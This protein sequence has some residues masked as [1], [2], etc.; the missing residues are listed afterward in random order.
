MRRAES[1]QERCLRED[2]IRVVGVETQTQCG[3]GAKRLA[4]AY[5]DRAAFARDRGRSAGDLE[6]YRLIDSASRLQGIR[7]RKRKRTHVGLVGRVG[8]IALILH[9]V[10]VALH[11]AFD[12]RSWS[13]CVPDRAQVHHRLHGINQTWKAGF[14]GLSVD[15]DDMSLFS[16]D[17][18]DWVQNDEA[19][20]VGEKISN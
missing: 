5:A 3:R 18:G 11:E 12:R 16:C 9:F 4:Y 20:P 19:G 14:D 6:G 10:G 1:A 13:E 8:P 15:L 2:G 17:I 7:P